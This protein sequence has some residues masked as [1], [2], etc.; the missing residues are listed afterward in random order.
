VSVCRKT[1]SRISRCCIGL[2]GRLGAGWVPTHCSPPPPRP[3]IALMHFVAGPRRAALCCA[4]PCRAVP[5]RAVPCRAV[6]CRAVL[7]CAV[8]CQK[9]HAA[10][11]GI[12]PKRSAMP[13]AAPGQLL[14]SSNCTRLI[15][16]ACEDA[17]ACSYCECWASML[18]LE[19]CYNMYTVCATSEAVLW[20]KQ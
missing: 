5:C 1:H 20:M 14:P 19:L 13:K 12:M 17:S 3:A 8:R 15:S 7:C 2:L 6:P 9:L 11:I 4:V 18:I 16:S 10:H